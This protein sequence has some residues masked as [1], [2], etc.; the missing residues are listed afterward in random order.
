M[1]TPI[2]LNAAPF[3]LRGSLTAD[4]ITA[5][6]SLIAG[7]NLIQLP[8]QAQWPNATGLNINVLPNGTGSLTVTFKS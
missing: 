2:T 8:S 1:S 5:L 4:Q 6:V 7:A 3:Q